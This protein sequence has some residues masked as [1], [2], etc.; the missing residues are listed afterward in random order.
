MNANLLGTDWHMLLKEEL[1]KPYFLQLVKTI[2]EE[3]NRYKICPPPNDVFKVFLLTPPQDVKVIILGQDPY[4]FGDHAH[5]LAF[6]S[7]QRE[8]PA[9][10]RMVFREVDR[11]VVKTRTQQEYNE[12]FPTNNLTAWAKQ[13]VF[14]LNSMLTVRAGL[15]G[16]H[17]AIGWQ[18]FTLAV[19]KLLYNDDKPKVFMSW[20]G[21]AHAVTN[22]LKPL[23]VH[24]H[25]I[26]EAGHPAS[27]SHGKDQYSGCNHF[28]KANHY[29]RKRGLTEINWTLNGKEQEKIQQVQMPPLSEDSQEG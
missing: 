2:T 5:G 13:G 28:S 22:Q 19:L 7:K 26:L 1:K 20:G 29:L 8:V 21:E 14:L 10:L 11:D 25:I 16:S 24:N 15:P 6:S 4:P 9:S 3:Y 27:G 23:G 12:A 17:G 18:E